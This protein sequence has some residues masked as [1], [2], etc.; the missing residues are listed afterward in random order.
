MRARTSRRPGAVP[1]RSPAIPDRACEQA[2]AQLGADG[3]SSINSMKED[4][5]RMLSDI[6]GAD[7]RRSSSR[8]RISI[9]TP[10][11][12]KTDSCTRATY[13]QA[14]FTLAGRAE[15]SLQSLKQ[16]AQV[17]L[18]RLGG[19]SNLAGREH[20]QYQ[21][22]KAQVDEAQRQ[23]DHTVVRAPFDGIVDAGRCPAAR[24]LSRVAD[25]GAHHHRR[26]RPRLDRAT[27]GS[28]PI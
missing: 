7:R 16:Q 15:D 26:G 13:D 24:H 25:R 6:D 17:A 1:D 4:Y 23:L 12:L 22:A 18:A 3:D 10:S 27:S 5:R 28:T 21:Q 9:A 19:N 11:L 14:R 2:K 8:K 20:P